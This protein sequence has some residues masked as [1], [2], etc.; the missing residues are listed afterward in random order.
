MNYTKTFL[1]GIAGILIAQS[2]ELNIVEITFLAWMIHFLICHENQRVRLNND[3]LFYR[4]GRPETDDQRQRR[5]LLEKYG[6]NF[7]Y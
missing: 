6:T 3:H 4:A 7:R 1:Y 2:F 5:Q